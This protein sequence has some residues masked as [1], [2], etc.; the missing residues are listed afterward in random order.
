MKRVEMDVLS[1]T[2]NCPV[3]H[4]AGRQFPGVLIQGD[5]LLILLGLAKEREEMT[6]EIDNEELEATIQTLKEKLS[7]YVGEYEAAMKVRGRELPYP[8]K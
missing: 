7:G 2:I 3:I 4:F 6:I 1:E 5:S 8:S